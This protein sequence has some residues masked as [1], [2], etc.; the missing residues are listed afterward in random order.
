MP[1]FFLCHFLQHY[2]LLRERECNTSSEYRHSP[3]K[4]MGY[5][6]SICSQVY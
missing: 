6:E 5:H 3:S 2:R 1:S 4:T